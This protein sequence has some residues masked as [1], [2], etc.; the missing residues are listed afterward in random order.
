[1]RAGGAAGEI[2]AA[3]TKHENVQCNLLYAH[4]A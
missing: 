1:M 3:T 2:L 4:V